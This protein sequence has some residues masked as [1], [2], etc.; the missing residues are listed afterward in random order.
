MS[1][2][3]AF[4]VGQRHS[5][6]K[7]LPSRATQMLVESPTISSDITVPA[8]PRRSTGLRPTRSESPPQNMPV[9]LSER[10]KDE[11]KRPA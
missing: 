3:G 2:R 6:P 7:A 4:T 9:R 1:D 11:M 8:H 10:A 5:P